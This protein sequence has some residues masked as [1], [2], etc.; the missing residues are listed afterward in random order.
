MKE[1]DFDAAKQG[2]AVCTRDGRPARIIC[3]DVDNMEYSMVANVRSGEKLK[4]ESTQL[5]CRDGRWYPA[6]TESGSDLM[7]RDDD[8]N[9][10]LAQGLYCSAPKDQ[11]KNEI[12]SM[13]Q[14][15]VFPNSIRGWMGLGLT[16]REYFAAMAM[17]GMLASDVEHEAGAPETAKVAV[18]YAD[19]L[20]S[21]I[22]K[23]E[24]EEWAARNL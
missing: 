17:Q 12:L 5:Y 10:R 22:N 11:D 13:F 7:M 20:T 4:S 9:R 3:F 18:K 19:A 24:V 21:E 1:F 15:S 8:Y 16:K 14:K 2:A 23:Q 6:A